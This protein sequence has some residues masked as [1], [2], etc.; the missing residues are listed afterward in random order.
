MQLKVQ[1]LIYTSINQQSSGGEKASNLQ[2][3]SPD[4]VAQ[5]IECYPITG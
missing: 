3:H 4:T 1:S 2:Y 5:I